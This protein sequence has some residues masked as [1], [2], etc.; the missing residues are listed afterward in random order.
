MLW[1]AQIRDLEILFVSPSLG[2]HSV[3]LS[4]LQKLVRFKTNRSL[5][6]GIRVPNPSQMQNPQVMIK[7]Y[8][9]K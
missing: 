2:F 7:D 3:S 4:L 6:I 8:K 5:S 9:L 1:C